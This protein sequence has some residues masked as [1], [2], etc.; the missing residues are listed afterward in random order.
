MSFQHIYEMCLK[1][2]LMHYNEICQDICAN[3]STNFCSKFQHF[4]KQIYGTSE[5]P[6]KF[7]WQNLY[8]E[9]QDC[10]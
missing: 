8:L 10:F 6:D 1:I 5:Y 7:F 4:F 9:I 2:N 3:S